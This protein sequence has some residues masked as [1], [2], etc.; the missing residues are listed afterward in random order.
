M[1]NAKNIYQVPDIHTDRSVMIS[2]NICTTLDPRCTA[3]FGVPKKRCCFRRNYREIT[4]DRTIID[5]LAGGNYHLSCRGDGTTVG[6]VKNYYLS[7]LLP[8][9]LFRTLFPAA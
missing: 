6:L 5:P 8:G 3:S 1:E 9:L 4:G 7:R 2:A